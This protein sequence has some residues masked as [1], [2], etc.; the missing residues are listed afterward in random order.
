ML[1]DET[2]KSIEQAIQMDKHGA[3][4][5]IELPINAY[6]EVNSSTIK[7]LMNQGFQGIYI[8]FQRPFKNVS[9]FFESEGIDVNNLLFI[10]AASAL[11]GRQQNVDARCVHISQELDIDELVKAIYQSLPKLKTQKKFIFIDSLTTMALYKPLSEIMRFSEFLMETVRK[12]NEEKVLLVFNVAKDLVQ[13]KFIRN[14]AFHV[15]HVISV[16]E[17]E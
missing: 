7:L 6:F 15:D 11:S 5:M 3:I 16:E 2:T 9:S 8:S 17:N 1:K 13:K 12:E 4:I 14:V 10:D